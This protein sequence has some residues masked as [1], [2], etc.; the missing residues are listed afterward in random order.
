MSVTVNIFT[1]FMPLTSDG[2]APA[3]YVF[4]SLI[5]KPLELAVKAAKR[6]NGSQA[7]D[8]NLKSF[9]F[10]NMDEHIRNA[11][12]GRRYRFYWRQVWYRLRPL[13]LAATGA[14][15]TYEYFSSNLVVAY[16]EKF[17]KEPMGCRDCAAH[18]THRTPTNSSRWAR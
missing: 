13:A 15:L 12:G 18:S 14:N 2:K 1:P 8:I 4:K 9:V 10:A 7:K 6:T 17:G 16:E 3:L 11:S 5:S